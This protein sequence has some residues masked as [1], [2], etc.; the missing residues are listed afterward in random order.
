MKKI[1]AVFLTLMISI[2]LFLLIQKRN[3]IITSP[4]KIQVA[5]SF[6]PLYFFTKEIGGDKIEVINITPAGAEPHDYE[7]TPQ[8][9]INIGQSKLLVLNGNLE[10]W[11]NKIT[12]DLKTKDIKVITVGKEDNGDPHTWLSPAFAKVD[13]EKIA[14]MLK[15][16]D[17]KNSNYYSENETKLEKELEKINGDYKNG[18]KN[19]QTRTFVTSHEAFSYLATDY[20]LT[21]VSIAGLSPDNEPSLNQL[22]AITDVV[23]KNNVKF[24]FFE[25][26][27]SPKLAQ[28]IAN[29]V[30]AQTLVL[31][32]IEGILP[33]DLS[34][35]VNYLTLMENNLQNLRKAMECK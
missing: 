17:P 14:D 28:T 4:N 22:A 19:C 16:I 2:V 12:N 34:K 6:Y 30:G 31:D 26:L 13:S 7:L 33:N 10:P 25:S 32:P 20:G 27:A 3:E 1:L 5:A 24:I 11:G 29:E 21:Q 35:G 23:K 8:D 15:T 9:V 18:L